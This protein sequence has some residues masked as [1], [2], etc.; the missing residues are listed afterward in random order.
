MGKDAKLTPYGITVLDGMEHASPAEKGRLAFILSLISQASQATDQDRLDTCD[1]FVD[2]LAMMITDMSE[3]DF[4]VMSFNLQE[5]AKQLSER[6]A[7]RLNAQLGLPPGASA[8]DEP[9]KDDDA[10][11]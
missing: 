11:N 2:A 4:I 7:D 8:Y 5:C 6:C 3:R 1:L 10:I 9:P